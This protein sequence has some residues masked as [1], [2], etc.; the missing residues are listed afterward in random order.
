MASTER[1]FINPQGIRQS[2][3]YMK[4]QNAA[5]RGLLNN[6]TNE[7]HKLDLNWDALGATEMTEAFETLKPQFEAFDNYVEKI[8]TFLDQNVAENVQSLDKAIEGNAS[9]LKAR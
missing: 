7:I 5:M 2:S 8:T 6:F 1:I 3:T 9:R 4:I